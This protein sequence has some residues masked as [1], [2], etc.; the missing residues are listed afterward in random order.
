[1]GSIVVFA[2]NTGDRAAVYLHG[3]DGDVHEQLEEFFAHEQ[4]VSSNRYE[5]RFDDPEYLAAR[6][7][8]HSSNATGTG[9]GVTLPDARDE[10]NYRVWCLHETRPTVEEL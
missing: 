10:T 3:D 7:V 5:L 9:V 2:D 6:F 4:A 1:M 8:V